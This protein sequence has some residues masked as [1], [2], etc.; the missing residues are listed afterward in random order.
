MLIARDSSQIGSKDPSAPPT[1]YHFFPLIGSAVSYGIDPYAFFDKNRRK[2]GDVFTFVLLNKRVTCALG[3]AGSNLVL[4]GKLSEVN[5][6]E[7][8]TRLSASD[9]S[10]SNSTQLA[11]HRV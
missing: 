3:P 5:A 10:A 7:A 4:N 2:Y 9:C 1:V 6:E 8:Y 11:H